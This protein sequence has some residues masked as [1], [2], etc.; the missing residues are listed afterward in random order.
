VCIFDASDG[1]PYMK[2]FKFRS[3]LKTLKFSCYASTVDFFSCL[4]FIG[5]TILVASA[6]VVLNLQAAIESLHHGTYL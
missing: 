1:T 2:P 3:S 4:G 5:W 6:C